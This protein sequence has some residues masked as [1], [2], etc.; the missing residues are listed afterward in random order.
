MSARSHNL[1]K[2]DGVTVQGAKMMIIGDH[3]V[4]SVAQKVNYASIIGAGQMMCLKEHGSLVASIIRAGMNVWN[5]IQDQR[6]GQVFRIEAI[7]NTGHQILHPGVPTFWIP[8]NKNVCRIG[9]A[10][11]TESGL[12]MDFFVEPILQKPRRRFQD[13]FDDFSDRSSHNISRV[14]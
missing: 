14:F 5:Q 2:I 12:A 4:A 7:N 13:R 8:G 6:I 11:R 1:G 3:H 10:Y 9:S